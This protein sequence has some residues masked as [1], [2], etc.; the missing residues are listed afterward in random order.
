MTIEALDHVNLRTANLDK[1]KAFYA[2]ALGLD[3]AEAGGTK[4]GYWLGA[5][6]KVL[7]HIIEAERTDRGEQPQIEHF[8]FRARGLRDVVERL[9]RMK[10]VYNLTAVSDLSLVRLNLRD[11]D[12]NRVHLDFPIEEYRPELNPV[13][14]SPR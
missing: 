1:L 8:A 9:N 2:D 6:G 5:G 4:R 13:R 11:P 10:L 14:V 7:L 3:A 12:A